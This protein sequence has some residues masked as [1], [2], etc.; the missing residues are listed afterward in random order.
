MI[1][2]AIGPGPSRFGGSKNCNDWQAQRGRYMHRTGII[3]HQ[4][5]AQSQPFNHLRQGGLAG[6]VQAPFRRRACQP[7]AKS[8][9]TLAAENNEARIRELRP[10]LQQQFNEMLDGPALVWPS[11]PRV[12]GD[13]PRTLRMPLRLQ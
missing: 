2:L 10:Q 1:E 12:Q 3:S 11:G 5:F 9:L 4:Q 8:F 13:P 6:Q 7:S